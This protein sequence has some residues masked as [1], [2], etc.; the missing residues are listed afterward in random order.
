MMRRLLHIWTDVA[1][2]A[3]IELA[4]VVP[5]LGVMALLSHDVWQNSQATQK[6]AA[7][8]DI[9][10]EYYFNGGTSDSTA[11]RAALD[12]WRDRSADSTIQIS[13]QLRCGATTSVVGICPDGS[14]AAAYAM[15]VTQG[16]TSGM[17]LNPTLHLV[18]SVR[19]G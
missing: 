17:L 13:R 12:G 3:T 5:A 11:S 2:G 8:V 15:I 4:L 7:A 14:V 9:A 16:S 18:R 10:V 19:V 1:G 6:A